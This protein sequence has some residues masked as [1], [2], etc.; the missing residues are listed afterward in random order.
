MVSLFHLMA[1]S[2]IAGV[3][4]GVGIWKNKEG[5]NNGDVGFDFV[6]KRF[7]RDG[8]RWFGLFWW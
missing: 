7:W 3:K 5:Q 4:Q 2:V 6:I 1:Q 8:K